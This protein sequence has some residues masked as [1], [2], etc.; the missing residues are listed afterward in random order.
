LKTTDLALQHIGDGKVIAKLATDVYKSLYV[1]NEGKYQSA[2]TDD[3]TTINAALKTASASGNTSAYCYTDGK[4]YYNVPIKHLNT[5]EVGEGEGEG[6]THYAKQ[7][8]YGVVRN[9]V[10]KLVVKELTDIGHAVADA[11]A[12]IVPT[13]EDDPNTETYGIVTRLNI[14]NWRVVSGNDMTLK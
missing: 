13:K 3:E 11:S 5:V 10:Y 9:H 7:G 14:L 8:Y 1:N 12:P 2:T 4:L 6:T